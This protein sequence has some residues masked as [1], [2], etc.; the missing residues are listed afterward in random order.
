MFHGTDHFFHVFLVLGDI[1]DGHQLMYHGLGS[2]NAALNV[3]A[4]AAADGQQFVVVV[5]GA[6]ADG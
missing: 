1:G 6:A 2:F 5:G 4:L 3:V